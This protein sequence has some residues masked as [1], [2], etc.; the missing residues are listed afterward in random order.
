[1]SHCGFKMEG[2]RDDSEKC[3]KIA[4]NHIKSG[5]K[6]K[7]IKFLNKA[8]KL[9]PSKTAT[10]LYTNIYAPRTLF[11]FKMYILILYT[12]SFTFSLYILLN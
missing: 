2:N 12:T 7:A 5:D 4:L 1:M 6:D 3:I 10:S 9:Y 8:N 11:N